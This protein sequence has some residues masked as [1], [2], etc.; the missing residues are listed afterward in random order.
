MKVWSANL[1]V[2]LKDQQEAL[3]MNCGFKS[4]N[5]YGEFDF[6]PYSKEYSNNMITVAQK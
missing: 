3:L 4:M 2:F 1:T 5:F 6:S